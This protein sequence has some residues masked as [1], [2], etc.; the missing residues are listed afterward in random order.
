MKAEDGGDPA[1]TSTSLVKLEIL[2]NFNEPKF[3]PR[4]YNSEI[5][6]TQSIGLSIVRVDARDADTKVSVSAIYT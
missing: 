6:E 2:R 4:D 1:K 3:S 5:L